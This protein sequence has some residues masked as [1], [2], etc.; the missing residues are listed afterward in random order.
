MNLSS[1]AA[2]PLAQAGSSAEQ[3]RVPSGGNGEDKGQSSRGY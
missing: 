3:R 1:P 2:E